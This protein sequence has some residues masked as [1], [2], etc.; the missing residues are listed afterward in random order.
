MNNRSAPVDAR[1]V[2][3]VFA[4]ILVATASFVIG[5]T[6][7]A[8]IHVDGDRA[9]FVELARLQA[10][11]D[12][13]SALVDSAFAVT[14]AAAVALAEVNTSRSAVHPQACPTRAAC[15]SGY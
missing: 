8:A 1:P 14:R 5:A 12:S 4:L 11:R 13:V 9:R 3:Y 6:T 7:Q 10:E 2:L 15:L